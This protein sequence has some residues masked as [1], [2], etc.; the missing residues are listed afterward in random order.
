MEDYFSEFAGCVCTIR[1]KIPPDLKPP[2]NIT[3]YNL[4]AMDNKGG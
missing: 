2:R 4:L 1:S 3:I